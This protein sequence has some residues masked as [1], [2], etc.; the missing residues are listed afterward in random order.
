MIMI[1]EWQLGVGHLILVLQ[2]SEAATSFS[3]ES[4]YKESLCASG[5]GLESSPSE[6]SL[7]TLNLNTLT[8]SEDVLNVLT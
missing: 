3:E 6:G 1:T 7:N 2:H 5:S 4:F 8:L